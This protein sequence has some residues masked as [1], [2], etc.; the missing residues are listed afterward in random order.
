M[1]VKKEKMKVYLQYFKKSGKWYTDASY[2]TEKELL[3][4][5]HNEVADKRYKGELPGLKKGGGKSF[6]IHVNVPG[7]MC[8]E[9][10]IVV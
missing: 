3:Y 7:H 5:I 8:S 9:P 6:M 4:E 2:E 10:H 1:G